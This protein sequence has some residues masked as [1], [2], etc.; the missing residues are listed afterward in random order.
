MK[1]LMITVLMISLLL[2]GCSQWM[3]GSYSAVIPHTEPTYQA[4]NTSI[5]VVNY[6]QLYAAL[7]TLVEKGTENAVL[8]WPFKTEDLIRA[9]MET[10][11]SNL[12]QFN[13]FAAY[14]VENIRY[15][16]GTSGKQIAVSV[17]ISYYSNRARPE[18]ILRIQT[19]NQVKN[20]VESRLNDCDASV[21]LYFDHV[22]Q[23]DYDQMVADYALTY[24]Q[25]VMEAPEVTVSLYPEEGSQ[26]VVELKFTYRT[27]RESLRTMQNKVSPVFASAAQ[28]VSGNYSDMEKASRLYTFL[29]NRYEYNIQT[30]ITPAYSLLLH[31]VGDNRAFAMVYGAMCRNAGIECQIVTGTRAGEPWIWNVMQLDGE[32]Y[33]LDL[34]QSN[35]T[36]EFTLRTGQEMTDYVWDYS[37]YPLNLEENE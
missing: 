34:L 30:S 8:S 15:E 29:M 5:S 27:S 18:K 4:Q 28:Y 16:L 12:M 9:D 14:A 33:H 37:A 17:H 10:A 11:V 7:I 35:E 1:K 3:D 23:V 2:A 31:G 22:E 24:P 20:V 21:V 36:G 26:Q 25:K 13:P 19:L 32:Y 6:E